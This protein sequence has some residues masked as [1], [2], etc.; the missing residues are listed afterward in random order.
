MHC[1]VWCTLNSVVKLRWECQLI[2]VYLML[3]IS[4]LVA[5]CV[6]SYLFLFIFLL[7]LFHLLWHPLVST[8]PIHDVA[9]SSLEYKY[10]A[11]MCIAKI[12]GNFLLVDEDVLFVGRDNSM[13]VK[14]PMF[15]RLSYE[16]L[17]T[18]I[19]AQTS[20]DAVITGSP[21]V[22]KT[23]MRNYVVHF[24]IVHYRV[25]RENFCIILDKSP[26]IVGMLHV[27]KAEF[28][29]HGEMSWSA[30]KIKKSSFDA[31][32]QL[33][34][35]KVWC[36]LD[37]S[38]GKSSDRV[39]L[40]GGAR[41]VMFTSPNVNA[42]KEI[43]KQNCE[44]YYL[45]LWP[46][47][48]ALL[49]RVKTSVTEEAFEIRWKKYDGVARALFASKAEFSM[50]ENRISDALDTL[51]S[52]GNFNQLN[53]T[54]STDA[55]CHM[56]F[57]Y[58]VHV[59]GNDA[60]RTA[61]LKFGSDYIKD[62]VVGKL[63][64]KVQLDLDQV[65]NELSGCTPASLKGLVLEP[66]A[67]RLLSTSKWNFRVVQLGS[68]DTWT[69]ELK[70]STPLSLGQ[71]RVHENIPHGSFISTMVEEFGG[72][73]DVMLVPRDGYAVVDAVAIVG[74]GEKRH[75]LFLQ[76]TVGLRHPVNGS[77]AANVLQ[78]L[79]TTAGGVG[80]CALIFVLPENRNFSSF[81]SQNVPA[82]GNNLRQYKIALIAEP[83]L[84][85]DAHVDKRAKRDNPD[86]K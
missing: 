55:M 10:W 20:R 58:D 25:L 57:Y 78:Q 54:D 21:G 77:D 47:D 6:L 72:Q 43:I 23:M 39:A 66:L 18:L 40:P 7:L 8:P 4:V 38:E 11:G 30:S 81:S 86:A 50:Y 79:I 29:S 82:C 61:S 34:L 36:L 44:L 35:G 37:V 52:Q 41:L 32:T 14:G 84:D 69:K 56:L 73:D 74:T 2:A 60:F 76:V 59:N 16:R 27:F 75:C 5:W 42:Y 63:T 22:G 85:S 19:F 49:A 46:K 33:I 31:D 12:E 28:D 65:M 17:M 13:E 80:K 26:S 70:L 68:R 53:K 24:L 3:Y 9:V 83:I 45:D 71:L 67:L 48:E 64:Q 62:L 51:N 1:E 15:V